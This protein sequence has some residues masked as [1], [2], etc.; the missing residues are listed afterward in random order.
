MKK[1]LLTILL[2]LGIGCTDIASS[3]T[4]RDNDRIPNHYDHCPD[5]PASPSSFISLGIEC[6][7][8]ADCFMLDGE[9]LVLNNEERTQWTGREGQSQ[10]IFC[11]N[12]VCVH[13]DT[14]LSCNMKG[15]TSTA[16]DLSVDSADTMVD[17]DSGTSDSDPATLPTGPSFDMSLDM[18]LPTGD[19]GVSDP[20]CG[21]GTVWDEDQGLCVP[22]IECTVEGL[23]DCVRP[24][25]NEP[26][27]H[28]RCAS[29][30]WVLL[31]T[32]EAEELCQE[33]IGCT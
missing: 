20:P 24:A 23:G 15:N 2:L 33:D 22:E 12:N 11:R 7:E 9:T 25:D 27:Q 13:Q 3:P 32:C 17:T 8:D 31:D 18:S 10:W 29:G 4:D 21:E 26:V 30:V 16:G 6:Q 28:F 1:A 19:E 14:T 5:D